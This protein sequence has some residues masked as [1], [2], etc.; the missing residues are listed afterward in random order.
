MARETREQR[1]APRCTSC[2]ANLVPAVRHGITH[3]DHP[4]G[5]HCLLTTNA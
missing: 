3:W 2:G 1:E 5:R 4:K